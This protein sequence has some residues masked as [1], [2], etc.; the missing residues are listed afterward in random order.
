MIELVS[1]NVMK[2]PVL[3]RTFLQ[4]SVRTSKIGIGPCYLLA[5]CLGFR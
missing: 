3:T 4:G 1:D 5:D 2:L